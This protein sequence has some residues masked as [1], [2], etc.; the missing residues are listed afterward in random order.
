[1]PILCTA[2]PRD[3]CAARHPQHGWRVRDT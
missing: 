3:S 2:K 1:V